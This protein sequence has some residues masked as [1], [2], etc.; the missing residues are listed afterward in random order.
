MAYSIL[1]PAF[2]T[3]VLAKDT[4]YAGQALRFTSF[5]IYM[6]HLRTEAVKLSQSATIY[7]HSFQLYACLIHCCV[8]IIFWCLRSG[9]FLGGISERSIPYTLGV[10]FLSVGS[11]Q[12]RT[13]CASMAWEA[14]SIPS[15]GRVGRLSLLALGGGGSRGSNCMSCT[16]GDLVQWTWYSGYEAIWIVYASFFI[17]RFCDSKLLANARIACR[18][19]KSPT[20]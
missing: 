1:D 2:T 14:E 12:P 4:I 10:G 6:C 16:Y 5:S 20:I 11:R 13:C 3:I 17:E 8:S 18:N 7:I 19:Q 9:V 15:A